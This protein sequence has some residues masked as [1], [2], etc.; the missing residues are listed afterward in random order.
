MAHEQ[1]ILIFADDNY[2]KTN[3]GRAAKLKGAASREKIARFCLR[4]IL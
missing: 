4:L 1:F 2:R 3:S